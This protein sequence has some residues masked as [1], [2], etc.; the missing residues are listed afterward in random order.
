[1]KSLGQVNT[2]EP[3]KFKINKL[4]NQDYITLANKTNGHIEGFVAMVIEDCIVG[5]GIK[6]NTPRCTSISL[7]IDPE[8]AYQINSTAVAKTVFRPPGR[9]D[10]PYWL[11][12][13]PVQARVAAFRDLLE[14][15][16]SKVSH[17]KNIGDCRLM[18]WKCL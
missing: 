9:C 16:D 2:T 14:W 1:M 18:H 4:M 10:K 6:E 12:A 7:S 11:S 15:I 13:K 17:S 3:L 8:G 5:T